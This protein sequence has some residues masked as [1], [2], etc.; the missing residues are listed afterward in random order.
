[1]ASTARTALLAVL[2]LLVSPLLAVVGTTPAHAAVS[3][4]PVATSNAGLGRITTAPDGSMW[5]LMSDANK[6]GRITTAGQIQ[7]FA[8]PPTDSSVEGPANGLDVGPDGVVW[9][10]T[11]HGA[12]V[13]RMSPAGQV[14]N[15][16]QFPPDDDPCVYTCPYAGEVRVGPDGAAW[17]TMNYDESFVV[18]MFADGRYIRSTNSPECADVLGEAADGSWASRPGRSAR[19]GS[20]AAAPTAH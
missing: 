5:F 7:E 16:F 6:V 10:T 15:N 12:N 20:P 4:F 2:A 11:E 3:V 17:I 1:M 14:L 13:V 19:S 8:L 18:K 9:V